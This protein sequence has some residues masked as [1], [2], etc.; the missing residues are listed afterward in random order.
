MENKQQYLDNLLD[1]GAEGGVLKRLDSI[2]YMGKKPMWQ[3]MKVKQNDTTDLVIIGFE[4]PKKEYTGKNVEGWKYWKDD[5]P[6]TEN[7][8]RG[9]I[10][11]VVFGAYVDGKMTQICT[12]SGMDQSIRQQMSEQPDLFMN[13]VARVEFMELTEAGYPRHPAYKGLH[14]DKQPHECTWTFD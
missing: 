14:E 11:S 10:G 6:V 12:A 4:P 9:W 1:T 3:W 2:Y 13:K 8:Y 7:Y 5:I